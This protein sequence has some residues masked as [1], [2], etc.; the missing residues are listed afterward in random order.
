[1]NTQ[2]ALE[3]LELPSELASY[4]G[5]IT[6]KTNRKLVV[7]EVN[8]FRSGKRVV[9]YKWDIVTYNELFGQYVFNAISN[10][11]KSF[12]LDFIGFNSDKITMFRPYTESTVTVG[13]YA[14]QTYWHDEEK[15][16]ITQSGYDLILRPYLNT[17]SGAFKYAFDGTPTPPR[18]L[19]THYA[20][21]PTNPALFGYRFQSITNG[22]NGQPKITTGAILSRTFVRGQ[23]EKMTGLTTK[24]IAYQVRTS[25]NRVA[26]D[27]ITHITSMAVDIEENAGKYSGVL[28]L[29][30][31]K[32]NTINAASM[33][34]CY[35]KLWPSFVFDWRLYN[36]APP[37]GTTTGASAQFRFQASDDNT[38]EIVGGTSDHYDS[39]NK[40]LTYNA[41]NPNLAKVIAYVEC[42]PAQ[43]KNEN[44]GR[45]FYPEIGLLQSE[46][47]FN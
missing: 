14:G 34:T 38:I 39:V 31:E 33:T 22:P 43:G 11:N 26:V 16:E 35:G 29:N 2:K 37:A 40:V 36:D 46:T 13:P 4:E 9:S 18:G 6:T 45:V 47:N 15:V 42:L 23:I 24:E 28:Y 32:H 20:T 5:Q 1:M 41:E 7:T 44:V 30:G 10:Q 17:S 27:N 19:P 25:F 21:A 8:D 12:G 3:L